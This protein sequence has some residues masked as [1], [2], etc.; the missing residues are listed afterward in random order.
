MISSF[1]VTAPLQEKRRRAAGQRH[2]EEW[3]ARKAR[4]GKDER[5]TSTF[6]TDD[7]ANVAG[8]KSGRRGDAEAARRREQERA[9]AELRKREQEESFAAWVR[10]K[11]RILRA[12]RREVRCSPSQQWCKF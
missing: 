9:D 8:G 1:G 2:W 11:D 5:N 12:R 7:G 10:E 3:V 4:G 6:G